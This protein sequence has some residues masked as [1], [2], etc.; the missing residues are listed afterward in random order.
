L[1]IQFFIFAST[2]EVDNK[3]DVFVLFLFFFVGF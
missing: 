2:S 1:K 3:K